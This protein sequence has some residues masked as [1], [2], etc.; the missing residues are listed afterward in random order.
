MSPVVAAPNIRSTDSTTEWAYKNTALAAAAYMYAATAHGLATCPM[1]GF[2]ERRLCFS[3]GIDMERY[4][5][6]MIVSTGYSYGEDNGDGIK[7]REK[8]KPRFPFIDMVEF[9]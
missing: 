9:K 1:E 7:E 5:V 2:D 3:L 8:S 6:P 4:S